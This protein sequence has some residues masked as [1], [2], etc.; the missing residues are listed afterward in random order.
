VVI[1][2]TAHLV[3]FKLF[4]IILR[5]LEHTW[6]FRQKQQFIIIII[7]ISIISLGEFFLVL[8]DF[9]Y[10]LKGFGLWGVAEFS[11]R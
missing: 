8:T 6:N 9:I 2:S 3:G 5:E 4:K 10:P 11:C 1:L 7:S